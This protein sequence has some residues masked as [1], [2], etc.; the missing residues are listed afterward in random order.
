MWYPERVV[1]LGLWCCRSGEG[2][3]VVVCRFFCAPRICRGNQV[4]RIVCMGIV[5]VFRTLLGVQWI[6]CTVC[7]TLLGVQWIHCSV[8]RTLLGVQWIHCTPNRV[9][10]TLTIPIHTIWF[11]WFPLQIRGAQ[12][13]LH[14][15]TRPLPP[16][17]N[18][19]AQEEQPAQDTTSLIHRKH[20][21]FIPHMLGLMMRSQHPPHTNNNL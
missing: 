19:R 4:N 7:R 3:R 15:A 8:C 5:S 11:T 12:K 17:D 20:T 6:H 10:H 1:L 13:N 14:T 21:Q 16:I 18:S 2:G 9:E